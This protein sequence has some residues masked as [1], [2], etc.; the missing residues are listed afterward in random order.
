MPH[1]SFAALCVCSSTATMDTYHVRY[2][3]AK[4]GAIMHMNLNI[5]MDSP[6]G[7]LHPGGVLSNQ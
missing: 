6:W 3:C 1:F 7:F 4:T 2:S 5:K